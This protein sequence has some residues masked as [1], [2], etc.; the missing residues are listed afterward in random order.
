[1]SQKLSCGQ[2][3]KWKNCFFTEFLVGHICWQYI[4]YHYMLRD[5]QDKKERLY[6]YVAQI[7]VYPKKKLI[8]VGC[9]ILKG[10]KLYK[11][12]KKS[13]PIWKILGRTLK[14]SI[15]LYMCC[16]TN[17]CNASFL[18]MLSIGKV[19]MKSSSRLV[20]LYISY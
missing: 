20:L 10:K 7:C 6:K 16:L 1:M 18:H 5:S 8:L 13:G 3:K 9:V 19:D 17:K 14:V 4:F 11:H 15:P 2:I 12:K